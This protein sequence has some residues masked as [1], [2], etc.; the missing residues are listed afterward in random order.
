MCLPGHSWTVKRA[1]FD[2]VVPVCAP[3]L[4]ALTINV[5]RGRFD[6]LVMNFADFPS[7]HSLCLSD[8]L[9][10]GGWEWIHLQYLC[11][12]T[13]TLPYDFDIDVNSSTQLILPSLQRLDLDVGTLNLVTK[14]LSFTTSSDLGSVKVSWRSPATQS[15]IYALFRAVERVHERSPNF[16][17]LNIQCSSPSNRSLILPADFR[18]PFYDLPVTGTLDIDDAFVTKITH[19]WPG[20]EVLYLYGSSQDIPRVSLGGIHE[21]LQRCQQLSSLG[22]QIDA[23]TVPEEE[24]QTLSLSLEALDIAYSRMTGGRAVEQYLR[25]LAPKVEIVDAA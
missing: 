23:R 4:R 14:L 16:G 21:L 20:I 8:F 15:D 6:P 17:T 13:M 5:W 2:P 24:P 7:L 9:S 3:S 12:L 18:D 25:I 22:I 1:K 11:D 19:S 10:R